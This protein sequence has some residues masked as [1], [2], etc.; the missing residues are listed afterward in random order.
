VISGWWM[1]FCNK[2][3]YQQPAT[4]HYQQA[5]N[6]QFFVIARNPA[7]MRDDE[8]IPLFTDCHRLTLSTFAMT[9]E[10]R[11]PRPNG[12]AMTDNLVGGTF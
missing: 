9:N 8:A 11:L 3:V 4:S 2:F 6:I 1:V 7:K 5:T 10:N 12:L